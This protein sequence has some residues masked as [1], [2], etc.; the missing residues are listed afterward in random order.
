MSVTFLDDRDDITTTYLFIHVR[1]PVSFSMQ[2]TPIRY[3]DIMV[4]T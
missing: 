3:G 2:K 1:V 4:S